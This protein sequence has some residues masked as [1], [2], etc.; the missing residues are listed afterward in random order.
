MLGVIKEIRRFFDNSYPINIESMC[1]SLFATLLYFYQDQ[2]SFRNFI[3]TLSRHLNIKVANDYKETLD[4]LFEVL[5]ELL[6]TIL[7]LKL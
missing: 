7:H 4:S 1:F 3:F 6:F 5:A 2:F